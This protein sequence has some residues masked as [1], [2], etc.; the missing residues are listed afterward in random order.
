MLPSGS[1]NDGQM[2]SFNHYAL[3]SVCRFLHEVVG[4]LS[5]AQ[6][7][8]S[9]ANVAPRPGGTVRSAKTKFDSPAGPYDCEWALDDDNK[10]RTRV[11]VPPNE[12]ARV[13]LHGV[14]EVVG[15]GEYVFET[16]W[17]PEGEWPPTAIPGP[18]RNVV[19][20]SFIP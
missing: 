16:V 6:P 7:G 17:E 2:T 5:P 18:Q 11:C 10:M 9:I 8:W 15:S 3:G 4:G 12:R 13:R 19:E 14:G 20:S 1:I